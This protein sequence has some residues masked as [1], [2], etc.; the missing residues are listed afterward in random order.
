MVWMSPVGSPMTSYVLP[1]V[2]VLFLAPQNH[3]LIVL[4]EIPISC[5]LAC[6]NYS[7]LFELS[8]SLSSLPH[9]PPTDL[10]TTWHL[11]SS[12]PARE[13]VWSAEMESHTMSCNREVTSYYLHHI[14]LTQSKSASTHPPNEGEGEMV[15]ILHM[16]DSLGFTLMHIC[17]QYMRKAKMVKFVFTYRLPASKFYVLPIKTYFDFI[18]CCLIQGYF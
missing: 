12:R 11:L 18:S 7:Q 3:S 10:L 8:F 16:C 6:T 15:G 14:L 9:N 1:R 13:S 4:T 2:R 5:W 17:P